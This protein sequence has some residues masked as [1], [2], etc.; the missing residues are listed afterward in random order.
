M[1]K[2]GKLSSHYASTGFYIV[3]RKFK[4]VFK[5]IFK[6]FFAF[7]LPPWFALQHVYNEDLANTMLCHAVCSGL[8]SVYIRNLYLIPSSATVFSC[9]F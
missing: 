3:K 5:Q 1:P 2:H 8:L 7:D 6:P 9:Y 4:R